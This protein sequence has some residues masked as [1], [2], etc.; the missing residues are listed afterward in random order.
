[1][2]RKICLRFEMVILGLNRVFGVRIGHFDTRVVYLERES[3]I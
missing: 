3:V 2:I 1:M